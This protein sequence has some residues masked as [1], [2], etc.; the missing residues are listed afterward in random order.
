L[1][2]P[3]TFR[4][5]DSDDHAFPASARPGEWAVSGG[6]V[7]ADREPALLTGRLGQAFAYGFLGTGSFG[8]SRLVEIAEIGAEAY[9]GVVEVLARHLRVAYDAPDL[10]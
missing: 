1:R 9:D 8:W 7:F 6:F 3:R 2:F 5:D 4:L 10:A